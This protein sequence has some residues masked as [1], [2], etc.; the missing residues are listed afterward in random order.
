MIV[1]DFNTI[2]MSSCDGND[3]CRVCDSFSYLTELKKELFSRS[4][5][6]DLV[7]LLI[8]SEPEVGDLSTEMLAICMVKWAVKLNA[9]LQ[10]FE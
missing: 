5:C 2:A 3:I 6:E 8:I 7:L 10:W 1:D 9:H 4:A